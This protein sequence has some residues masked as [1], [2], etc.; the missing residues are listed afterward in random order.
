MHN[1]VKAGSFREIV[2]TCVV[3]H[4]MLRTDQG[5]VDRVPTPADDIAAIANEQVVYAPDENCR[6][7]LREA[8]HQRDQLKD[9]F[10]H[11]GAFAGQILF[12]RST[13]LFQELLFKLMLH[14]KFQ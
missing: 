11:A 5:G 3:L 1:G 9:Y 2:L 13:Q 14:H 7:P 12:F 10:N 6:N 8:K 4:S